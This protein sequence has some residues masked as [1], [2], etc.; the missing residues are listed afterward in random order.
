MLLLLL[1]MSDWRQCCRHKDHERWCEL[2]AGERDDGWFS[3][4]NLQKLQC[5]S[6]VQLRSVTVRLQQ[7]RWIR[8]VNSFID[9]RRWLTHQPSRAAAAAAARVEVH[10]ISCTCPPPPLLAVLSPGAA[11]TWDAVRSLCVRYLLDQQLDANIRDI[12]SSVHIVQVSVRC[13][14][15]VTT[16][17]FTSW[18]LVAQPCQPTFLQFYPHDEFAL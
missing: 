10:I 12:L 11:C 4:C 7:L 3:C 8:R 5:H 15:I 14:S 9:E 1:L 18:C 17:T 2:T 6:Y 13:V 16:S